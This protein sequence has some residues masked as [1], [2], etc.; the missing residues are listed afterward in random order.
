MALPFREIFDNFTENGRASICEI[1]TDI[2]YHIVH[3]FTQVIDATKMKLKRFA[4]KKY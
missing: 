2:R 3:H 1:F 4:R